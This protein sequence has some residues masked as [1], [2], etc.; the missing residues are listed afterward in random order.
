MSVKVRLGLQAEPVFGTV[1]AS[2][3]CICEFLPVLLLEIFYQFST[4]MVGLVIMFS[5]NF[6]VISCLSSV[7]YAA[8]S[9]LR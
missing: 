8:T 6:I 3:V 1:A 5:V 4:H 9:P 2:Q 7:V